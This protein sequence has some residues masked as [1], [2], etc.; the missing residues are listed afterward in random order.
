MTFIVTISLQSIIATKKCKE[1]TEEKLAG[2]HILRAHRSNLQF[3]PQDYLNPLATEYLVKIT[4][5]G[6]VKTLKEALDRCDQYLRHV[7]NQEMLRQMQNSINFL[8]SEVSSL[9]GDVDFW[10]SLYFFD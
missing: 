5:D 10:S 2:I 3:L 1:A 8:R 7:E 6:R 9:R 4:A